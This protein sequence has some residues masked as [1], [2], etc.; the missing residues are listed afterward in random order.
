MTTTTDHSA[1]GLADRF[2]DE[3]T[4]RQTIEGLANGEL[5]A[6]GL[7]DDVAAIVRSMSA[8]VLAIAHALDAI[9][10]KLG[11]LDSH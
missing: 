10:A 3:S 8:E 4:R 6:T 11:G 2:A 1:T 7:G 9:D 5:V